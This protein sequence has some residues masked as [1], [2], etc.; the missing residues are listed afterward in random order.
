MPDDLFATTLKIASVA[1]T[2]AIKYGRTL[3]VTDGMTITHGMGAT[4]SS[5]TITP[6]YTGTFTQSV[7]TGSFDS[8]LITVSLKG[9]G[10]VTTL[11][12]VDWFCGK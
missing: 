9:T 8:T 11:T 3:A 4:P 5:C 1:F 7:Y 6:E 12:A 10:A 2:G